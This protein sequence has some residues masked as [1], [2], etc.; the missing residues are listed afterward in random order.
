MKKILLDQP[1]LTGWQLTK[2]SARN[3]NVSLQKL[4][5]EEWKYHISRG[6]EKNLQK[7]IFIKYKAGKDFYT[8]LQ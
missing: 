5:T 1:H 6:D 4:G 3:Q 2:I 7:I 8:Y